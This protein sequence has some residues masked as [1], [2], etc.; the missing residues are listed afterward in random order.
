MSEKVSSIQFTPS[1]L[2][3]IQEETNNKSENGIEE[4]SQH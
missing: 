3:E 2:K 4:K 1:L